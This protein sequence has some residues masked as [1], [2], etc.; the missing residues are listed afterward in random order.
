MPGPAQREK[1]EKEIKGPRL[2]CEMG[3]SELSEYWAKSTMEQREGGRE[4]VKRTDGPGPA[5]KEEGGKNGRERGNWAM[6][7]WPIRLHLYFLS[8]I[9]QSGPALA[10]V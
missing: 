8:S 1:K 2:D 6:G 4:A 3:R 5:I 9:L 10:L 7:T